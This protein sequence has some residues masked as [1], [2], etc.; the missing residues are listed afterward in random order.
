MCGEPEGKEKLFIDSI[1][2]VY[3]DQLIVKQVPCYPG[4]IRADLKTDLS[5]ETLDTIEYSCKH[6]QW[7]EFLVYDKNGNLIRGDVGSM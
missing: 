2:N 6:N 5:K 7:I 1:N 4:Y 3:Q